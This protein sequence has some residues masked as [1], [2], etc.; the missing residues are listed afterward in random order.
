MLLKIPR[1]RLDLIIGIVTLKFVDQLKY[2]EISNRMADVGEIP[3]EGEE[4]YENEEQF[5]MKT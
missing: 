4:R 3:S 2:F 1:C 5:F